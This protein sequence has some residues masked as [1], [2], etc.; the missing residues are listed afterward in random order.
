MNLVF[1]GSSKYS[2]PALKSLIKSGF[3]PIV[4]T[5]PDKPAGRHLKLQPNP[6]ALFARENKLAVLKLNKLNKKTLKK[7]TGTPPRSQ[8]PPR[9]SSYQI[10]TPEESRPTS[11]VFFG[12]CCVYGKIIPQIWF[13]YFDNGIINLHPSLL[14]KY[15]GPSPAQFALLNNE[16]ETGISFI[17]MDKICDHG[18]L[19][20]QE[21][22]KILPIDT[23]ES[24]YN[25]L[26]GLAAEKLPWVIEN[27]LKGKLKEI[28]QKHA[29]ASFT[30]MLQKQDGF[31]E[32][33]DLKKALINERL[34]KLIDR[35]IR[36]FTPWPGIY[37]MVNFKGEEKRLKILKTHLKKDL[38]MIEEVQLEG[39]NPVTF[40]QFSSSYPQVF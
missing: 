17:K 33:K 18:P 19:I 24:L 25:R 29:L 20:Y 10:F 30:K 2:I 9:R 37:T 4:V 14:P 11:G 28:P 3:K 38:L 13:D 6:L 40:L 15:R 35:K 8:S 22:D 16:A 39:K 21:K 31:I 23:A 7:L 27:F 32:K 26:F 36:A 5:I 12:I 1:F 34:A